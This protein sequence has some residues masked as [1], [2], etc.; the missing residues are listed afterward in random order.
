MKINSLRIND[1]P[2]ISSDPGSLLIDLRSPDDY[3]NSHLPSAINLPFESWQDNPDALNIYR[4]RHMY[5]Y[6]EHGN[7]SILAA[8]I[9]SEAGYQVVNLTGGIRSY[10]GCCL[11]G[12]AHSS[13]NS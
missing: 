5:L 1:L 8:R 11:R 10:H 6:C 3:R 12:S 13:N 4:N 2:M 9:L 7:V